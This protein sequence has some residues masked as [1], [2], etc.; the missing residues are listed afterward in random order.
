MFIKK[1]ITI[2]LF[3]VFTS[4]LFAQSDNQL[5]DY[6][7]Y[8]PMEELSDHELQSLKQMREEEKLARDVYMA[9][10]EKWNMNIF[11]NIAKSEQTHTD[12]VALIIKKYSLDDPFIDEYGVFADSTLQELYFTLVEI[13]NESLA[14]AV[15]IGCTIEDLDI[16]DLEEF[17]VDT[18][19]QDIRMVYQNLLKGSRN[20]ARSFNGQYAVQGKTY[21][22][23]FITAAEWEQIISA[24]SEQGTVDA[25]GNPFT[26]TSVKDARGVVELPTN[27]IAAQNYPNP[28]NPQTTIQFELP[29]AA[30][31]TVKI[32]DVRG[33]LVKTLA[34]NQALSAGSHSVI[35]NGTDSSENFVSSGIY[36]YRIENGTESL[37]NQMML[38]K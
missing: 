10:Y 33:K 20:H 28:F 23:Q 12:M 38:I 18:D 19:N 25:D 34:V 22:T 15:F 1:L 31:V 17:L 13:G 36:L 6:I 3:L 21:V 37:T 16:Y 24:S 26:F 9:L 35:W 32:Y 27:F 8:L 11:N 7:L 29:N 14:Q 5:N 4:G 2:G 30:N